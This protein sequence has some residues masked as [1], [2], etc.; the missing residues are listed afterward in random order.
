MKKNLLLL[1]SFLSFQVSSSFAQSSDKGN[2][3]EKTLRFFAN[4]MDLF[5]QIHESHVI[6]EFKLK[7]SKKVLYKLSDDKVEL[8]EKLDELSKN[9]SRWGKTEDNNIFVAN[10]LDGKYIVS[11][12]EPDEAQN[13]ASNV[14]EVQILPQE[15]D[16]EFCYVVLR[17]GLAGKTVPWYNGELVC[18]YNMQGNLVK[19]DFAEGK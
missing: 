15:C 17:F 16:V 14:L 3:Q 19:Y 1:V 13:A 2:L 5:Q 8:I 12:G 7:K 18:K 10:N 6:K 9:S 4:N 11:A